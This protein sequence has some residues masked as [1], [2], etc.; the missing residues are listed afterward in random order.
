MPRGPKLVLAIQMIGLAIGVFSAFARL[1]V[2]STVGIVIQVAIL[3]GLST[4]QTVA[5]LAAR[6][7]AVIGAVLTSI[8]VVVT[9][10]SLFEREHGTQL[11]VWAFV[12]VAAAVEWLFFFLLGWPDSRVYFNAPRKEPKRAEP[13]L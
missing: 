4:R 11:W 2:T 3:I 9:I 5:W 6:W 13:G 8:A 7:L 10:P 12:A 1:D